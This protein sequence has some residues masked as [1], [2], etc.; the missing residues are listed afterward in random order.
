MYNLKAGGIGQGVAGQGGALQI[1]SCIPGESLG[2]IGGGGRTGVNTQLNVCQVLIKKERMRVGM[3]LC[4]RVC[5]LI[6]T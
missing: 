2:A 1:Q 3:C 5:M 6:D 4:V